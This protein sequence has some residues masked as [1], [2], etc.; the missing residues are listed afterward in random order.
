M[1]LDGSVVTGSTVLCGR[2][3]VQVSPAANLSV[4]LKE[5]SERL[6]SAGSVTSNPFLTRVVL[7]E[8]GIEISVFPDGRAIIR[9]TEDS[10]VARAIYSRYIGA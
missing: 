6:E 8:S 1:F 4:S 9:G 7:E 5:L 10:A 2:N 3:A